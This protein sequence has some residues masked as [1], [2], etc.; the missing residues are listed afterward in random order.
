MKPGYKQTEVGVIPEDWDTPELGEILS[1]ASH[2]VR[3]KL[4]V[5]K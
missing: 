2:S 4:D 1:Q 3:Y 5:L